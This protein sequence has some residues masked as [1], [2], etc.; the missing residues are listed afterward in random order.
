MDMAEVHPAIEA[1]RDELVEAALGLRH[2]LDLARDDLDAD[3]ALVEA[4]DRLVAAS[5]RYER[6]TCGRDD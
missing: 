5:D 3:P 6:S 1:A 4:L 2:R